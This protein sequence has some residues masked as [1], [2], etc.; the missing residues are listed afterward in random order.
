VSSRSAC[1]G[2]VL[3]GGAASRFGGAAKGLREVGGIRILDRVLASLQ[4]AADDVMI[5]ANDAAADQWLPGVTVRR[6]VSAERGSLV[7][8]HSAL[9]HAG[10]AVLVVAWDMPFVPAALLIAL[11][12]LGESR[13]SAAVPESA[14]GAEP[15]CAYYPV[16]CLPVVERQL[17][18]KALRLRAFLD[19]LPDVAVMPRSKVAEFGDVREIFQNVNGPED[20]AAAQQAVQAKRILP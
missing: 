10:H 16:S 15:L 6:D 7:G 12:E 1:T 11:R 3:A 2:V 5:I 20:L 8:I 14:Q 4:R 13:G 9:V 18:R 19:A 17:A